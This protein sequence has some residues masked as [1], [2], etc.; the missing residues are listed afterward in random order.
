MSGDAVREFVFLTRAVLA[1]G[2]STSPKTYTPVQKKFVAGELEVHASFVLPDDQHAAYE[3]IKVLR[4]HEVENHIRTRV[5]WQGSTV[6][7][8]GARGYDPEIFGQWQA[9]L[10]ELRQLALIDALAFESLDASEEEVEEPDNDS[11]G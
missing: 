4:R 5:H 10:D 9:A 3:K 2:T 8:T 1:R 11:E 6:F 7:D